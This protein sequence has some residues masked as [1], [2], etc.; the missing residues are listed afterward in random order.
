M[1]EA[2]GIFEYLIEYERFNQK[3]PRNTGQNDYNRILQI[4]LLISMETIKKISSGEKI[5]K[6]LSIMAYFSSDEIDSDLFLQWIKDK[7]LSK[8]HF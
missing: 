1:S 3:F 2:F 8:L 4:K 5:L 6:V 7:D